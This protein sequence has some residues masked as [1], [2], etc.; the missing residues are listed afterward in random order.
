[1]GSGGG[2]RERAREPHSLS[3]K[4][5]FSGVLVRHRCLRAFGGRC[6][7][8]SFGARGMMGALCRALD[9]RI[10]AWD[11]SRRNLQRKQRFPIVGRQLFSSDAPLDAFE[12]W[13][14]S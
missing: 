13:A 2:T 6:G 1:D 3:S 8:A 10:W 4:R 14:D 5:I 7:V 12:D 9:S 11:R